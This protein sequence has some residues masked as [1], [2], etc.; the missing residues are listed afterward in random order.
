[1]K[2]IDAARRRA[3]RLRAEMH[4]QV[5]LAPIGEDAYYGKYDSPVSTAVWPWV[6]RLD[7]DR[8]RDPRRPRGDALFQMTHAGKM[9]KP[10]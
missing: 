4:E 5:G 1:M 2:L 6:D 10:W 8:G 7:H 3:E 9:Q